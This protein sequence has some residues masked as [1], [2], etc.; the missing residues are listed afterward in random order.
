MQNSAKRRVNFKNSVFALLFICV[1]LGLTERR[2]GNIVNLDN[3][4][5]FKVKRKTLKRK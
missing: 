2:R 4:R 5:V 1:R 3:D